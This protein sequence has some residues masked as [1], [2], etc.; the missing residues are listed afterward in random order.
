M[1]STALKGVNSVAFDGEHADCCDRKK[2]SVNIH[3]AQ[4]RQQVQTVNKG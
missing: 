4:I 1:R 2:S 3:E